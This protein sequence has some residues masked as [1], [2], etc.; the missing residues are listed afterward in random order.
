MMH[1]HCKNIFMQ[2]RQMVLASLVD[3]ITLRIE[4]NA[5]QTFANVYQ[6]VD[7]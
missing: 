3:F 1:P 5:R 6:W 2:I 7:Y 4:I